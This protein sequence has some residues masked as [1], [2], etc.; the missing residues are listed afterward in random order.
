MLISEKLDLYETYKVV[1][2]MFHDWFS[3]YSSIDDTFHYFS[4]MGDWTSI[5]LFSGMLWIF[6]NFPMHFLLDRNADI[7]GA[8][9]YFSLNLVKIVCIL[10]EAGYS[11]RKIQSILKKLLVDNEDMLTKGTTI[12]DLLNKDLRIL[13][14]DTQ[15]AEKYKH[16]PF[17]K[18]L[19][20]LEKRRLLPE[21]II[22][23]D[24]EVQIQL[25]LGLTSLNEK[26]EM[27]LAENEEKILQRQQQL[28]EINRK[29]A[30][31]E[32][33]IEQAPSILSS[34]SSLFSGSQEEPTKFIPYNPSLWG[35]D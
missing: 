18:T 14:P 28:V 11:N 30:R 15:I 4:E 16:H 22:Q 12:D 32:E 33:L 7:L 19:K 8:K 21:N 2:Q 17:K 6:F 3:E 13:N 25:G 24:K 26:V 10:E 29:N 5:D 9:L 35:Y 27:K 1:D 34:I 23:L 20:L 31:R